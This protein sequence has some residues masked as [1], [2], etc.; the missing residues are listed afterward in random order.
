MLNVNA[1]QR[2]KDVARSL[3]ILAAVRAKGVPAKLLMHMAETSNPAAPHL[4]LS[5]EAVGRQLG[6]AQ[7]TEWAHHG[8][9]FRKGN[10]VLNE[11]KLA[12]FYNV[13]DLYLTTTLGE[14]WGLGITEALAC[15]CPAAVPLHTS[16]QEICER[17]QSD[18]RG[19]RRMVGL[20][21]EP[22]GMVLDGDNSRVRR[23]VSVEHAANLIA[24][25][26]ESGEWRN[27]QPL[28]VPLA[29][30][31]SWDRVAMEMLRLLK[32]K[33]ETKSESALVSLEVAG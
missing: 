25:Y 18:P 4:G 21:I 17:V 33:P 2:R 12:K 19:Q 30:W 29:Q 20:P 5:L 11:S 9:Y 26:Y 22:F 23:R 27:R 3:E 8:V 28:P 14:G 31:L 32:R 10:P 7:L 24:D 13:A 1:N 16:C 6:F 15:G